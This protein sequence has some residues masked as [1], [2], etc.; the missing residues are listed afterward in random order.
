MIIFNS[1]NL[2]IPDHCMI[3]VACKLAYFGFLRLTEVVVPNLVSFS[4][5][6]HLH[7]LDIS[8]DLDS[9]PDS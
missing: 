9:H 5:A 7:V 8:V 6:R 1:L 4:P 3:W 2:S